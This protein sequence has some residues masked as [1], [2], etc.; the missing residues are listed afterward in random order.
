MAGKD[1]YKI[2]GVDKNA[3]ADDVKK[4]FRKLAHE[5]HPD[6]GGNEAKFKEANE[7]YQVL[8]DAEKRKQ[9]DQFGSAAFDGSGGGNP[10]AGGGNPFGGAGGFNFDF[11][12][13]GFEDLGD[14]L[15][16]MFGGGGGGRQRNPQ[17][18]NIEVGVRL[19][20]K[21]AVF[22][23]EKEIP[24]TRNS[25]CARCAG[26]A[27]EP[28]TKMQTCKTCEGKGFRIVTQRTMLGAM[29][30][31]QGCEECHGTGEKPEK[32]CTECKGNGVTHGRVTVRVDIPAGVDDGV[33][34][35]VRGE[36]ENIGARGEPGDLYLRIRVDADPRFTRDGFTI[37]VEKKI[38]FTQAALGDT[39]DV[40]TVDGKVEVKIPQG[41]QSGDELRLRG[42]G[43]GSA[44]GRGDQIVR[45]TVV[46]P[47]KL[48]KKTQEMLKELN[49]KM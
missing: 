3:S 10:F 29:Q 41:T 35:R 49:L 11:G 4:A 26:T 28:G 32:P 15:G 25:V 6:K 5:H 20:F 33:T 42:K 1:Y 37:Y 27:A 16:G 36:G 34:V 39:V 24:V 12:G 21:E 38:G 8:G 22:G 48:D 13:A 2:L 23:V 14:I 45:I 30:M 9:Y 31:R 40:D 7:A 17:G 18:E 43:V 47:T 44:R 46:T 19:S